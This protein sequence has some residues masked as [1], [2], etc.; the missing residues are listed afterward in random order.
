MKNIVQEY[1]GGQTKDEVKF[2]QS[3]FPVDGS[4]EKTLFMAT[5]LIQKELK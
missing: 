2:Q 1:L 5:P 3:P 4:F